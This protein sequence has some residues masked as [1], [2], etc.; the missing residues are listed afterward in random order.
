L[1]TGSPG[2][3]LANVAIS[4]NVI[5][6]GCP[7][8]FQY[9]STFL[10]VKPAPRRGGRLFAGWKVAGLRHQ[11]RRRGN[12]DLSSAS[13]RWH[14]DGASQSESQARTW[15]GECY[16]DVVD[17]LD[18]LRALSRVEILRY[19]GKVDGTTLR[20]EVF[21]GYGFTRTIRN[22]ELDAIQVDASQRYFL[23]GQ[24][25]ICFNGNIFGVR[26]FIYYREEA[27][28]HMTKLCMFRRTLGDA[29]KHRIESACRVLHT[30]GRVDRYS[31]LVM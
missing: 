14:S 13:G 4:G 19:L 18:A 17:I 11:Q 9:G 26:P 8:A 5:V 7:T 25:L 6:A 15:I 16:E 28:G 30:R 12:K 2:S 3:A 21:R 29:P 10:Y 20:C 1:L 31:F 23:Q 24:V 27:S 22:I